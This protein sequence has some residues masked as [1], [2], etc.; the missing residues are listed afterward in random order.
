MND[1]TDQTLLSH[2]RQDRLLMVVWIIACLIIVTALFGITFI[3]INADRAQQLSSVEKQT[4]ARA[5]S[6]V[7]Q[8][9]QTVSQIDQFSRVIKYQWERKA[10]VLDLEE[11]YK[12]GIYQTTFFPVVISAQGAVVVGNR[13]LKKGHYMGDL[14]FFI[15]AQKS[16]SDDLLICPGVGRGLLE[17]SP[18]IRFARRIVNAKGEFDGVVLIA[19][20]ASLMATFH[21]ASS[22]GEGDFISVRL[23]NG[24][25]L[26]SK[27]GMGDLSMSFYNVAPRFTES[28]GVMIEVGNRFIDYEDRIIAWQKI[29]EYSLITIAAISKKNALQTYEAVE[30]TYILIAAIAGF[31]VIVFGFIT[32]VIRSR[33]VTRRRDQARVRETFRLAVDSAREAFFMV[34]PSYDIAGELNSLI[35]EDCNERAAEILGMSRTLL[36][37]ANFNDIYPSNIAKKLQLFFERALNEGFAEEEFQVLPG[38]VHASGWFLRRAVSSGKD[39]AITLRDITESKQQAEL[40][41]NMARTDALTGLPNRYW[42]N[43]YLPSAIQRSKLIQKPLALF[44]L[45][46]DNFKDVNDSLGH[47]AGDDILCTVAEALRSVLGKEDQVARLGGDEFIIIVEFLDDAK[48]I[49]NYAI[50]IGHAI[51]NIKTNLPKKIFAMDVSIGVAIY[52]DHGQEMDSLIQSADIAMY[53]AKST[54]KGSYKIYEELFGQNIRERANAEYELRQAIELDQ[55]VVFYQPRVDAITGKFCGMEALVRWQHP[56]QGLLSPNFFIHVAERSG[57]IIQL[58]EVVIEKTCKQIAKWREDGWNTHSVSVNVSALQ[59]KDKNL[60][61]FLVNC[62]QRHGL[63]PCMLSIELTESTMLDEEGVASSELKRLRELGFHLLIDDFGT[64]QS[65]LSKLQSLDIDL[66]KIDQSFVVKLDQDVQ[67][68]ALCSA[69]VSIGRALNI[70]VV[71]EGVETPEQLR[72]LQQIGCDEVQ[73]YLISKPVPAHQIPQLMERA[74][75]FEPTAVIA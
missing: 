21:D 13:V 28:K 62:M 6:Y 1:A 42:L 8:V 63:T 30:K 41:E 32:W 35:I 44:Y 33:S 50:K 73:G 55:L 27:N 68:K 14:D 20:E 16:N 43:D 19:I 64:G 24:P 65:S 22:I 66:I 59:L 69:V 48:Q 5:A 2:L 72:I 34:R 36:L 67:S 11:Q 74:N 29:P 26:S 18:V 54:K 9:R 70:K 38:R 52:P 47:K 53:V 56:E 39:I 57:L 75:F 15:A 51:R 10:D 71:A 4:Q 58:G 60:R 49:E 46:L 23:D 17:G 3:K 61:H 45:D 25:V 12:K 31:L 40:L 7:E 37:G